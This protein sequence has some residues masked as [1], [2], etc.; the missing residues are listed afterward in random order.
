MY[1]AHNSRPQNKTLVISLGGSIL[2]PG[3]IDVEFLKGFRKIILKHLKRFKKIILVVG[4]GYT[5]RKYRAAAAAVAK[6]TSDDEDWLGI[7]S[8]RL[9]GH[10]LRTIFRNQAHPVMVTTPQIKENF[11]AKLLVA[12]GWR[13]GWSTD[14]VAVTLADVYGAGMI[15]NLSNI[16]YVF[17]K[18]PKLDKGAQALEQISWRDFQ[19]IVGNKWIPSGNFP[20][21]PVATK[22]AAKI[23]MTVYCLNGRNLANLD[24]FLLGKHFTGTRIG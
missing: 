4:G 18:D 11:K 6:I 23:G 15:L 1:K 12:A 16:D 20:F 3:E 22:L 7:H 14:Y 8:T 2:V 9:N 13:P 17:D 19:R 24:T 5:A 21:D 10:L